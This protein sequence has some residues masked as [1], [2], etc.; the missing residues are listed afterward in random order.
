MPASLLQLSCWAGAR[1][2]YGAIRHSQWRTGQHDRA[3]ARPRLDGPAWPGG[4][5]SC[6]I[7]LL[8]LRSYLRDLDDSCA[9]SDPTA[10]GMTGCRVYLLLFDKRVNGVKTRAWR[11]IAQF[12][13]LNAHFDT[14]PPA[15]HQEDPSEAGSQEIGD[16][17]KLGRN[18]ARFRK[19]FP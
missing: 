5:R 1:L 16:R 6:I 2:V 4:V 10:H 15:I 8:P 11:A 7:R 12:L 19:P 9:L 17:E 3:E 14:A 13:E 18:D